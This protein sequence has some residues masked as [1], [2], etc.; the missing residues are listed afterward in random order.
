MKKEEENFGKVYLTVPDNFDTEIY[1]NKYRYL[2]DPKDYLSEKLKK[3]DPFIA[4]R[5][6]SENLPQYQI[7]LAMARLS[8]KDNITVYKLK[9]EVIEKITNTDIDYM[10]NE[11]PEILTKPFIIETIDNNEVLFGDIISIVGFFSP[12]NNEIINT[13]KEN[14]EELPERIKNDLKGIGV[15]NGKNTML[16]I[17]FQTKNNNENDIWQQAATSL[18]NVSLS[19]SDLSLHYYGQNIFLWIPNLAKSDWQFKKTNYERDVFMKKYFCRLCKNKSFC[20]KDD[21][22]SIDENYNFCFEGICDNILS[23]ITIFNYILIAEH[24]PIESNKKREIIN[25]KRKTKK[26]KELIKKEEWITKYLYVN[27]EKIRYEG[28]NEYTKLNKEGLKSKEIKVKG[29][30]RNQAYGENFSLR[31]L[32]YIESFISTKWIRDGDTKIIVNIK[33]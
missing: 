4:E 10:P 21:R 26:N 13:Y 18:R 12:I 3:Y 11:I 25:R 27:N 8:H 2:L 24:S 9:Q 31:K 1:L 5:Y 22:Y 14:P 7:G 17:L 28:N 30:L 33:E 29:H 6:E 20:N 16:S 19:K 15:D 32:V 23:F